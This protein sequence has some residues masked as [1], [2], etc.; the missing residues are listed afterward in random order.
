MDSYWILDLF[1]VNEGKNITLYDYNSTYLPDYNDEEGGDDSIVSV[2][3]SGLRAY[4]KKELRATYGANVSSDEK[5]DT[6]SRP[7][8]RS[9]LQAKYTLNAYKTKGKES[10]IISGFKRIIERV[11]SASSTK[12]AEIPAKAE[13]FLFEDKS[14]PSLNT[15]FQDPGGGHRVIYKLKKGPDPQPQ[16]ATQ[17][18]GP[19]GSTPPS[20]LP[21]PTQS[22]GPSQS[23]G[24]INTP[25]EPTQEQSREE[26]TGQ[27]PNN[28]EN[29]E[30]TKPSIINVFEPTIKPKTI[31]YDLPPQKDQQ[32]EIAQS[33]GNIPLVWYNSYQ[34]EAQNI[35]YFQLNTTNNLPTIKLSF[36]DPLNLMKDK[37]FPLDDTKISIFINSRSEQLKPI[38]MDF[39]IVKFNLDGASFNLTGVVDVNGLYVKKFKSMSQMS[40]FKA[41]KTIAQETGLGFNTNIDDTNDK[42]T[43]ICTGKR[44]LEFIDD[45]V[46]TSYK[47]DETYLLSYID[48]YYN[49]TYVDIEKELSRNIKEELGVSNIGL[50][51]VSKIKDKERVS[52][53]FLSNDQSMAETN[54]FFTEYKIV[55]NSTSVSLSDGYLTKVKFYDELQKDFLVFDVDSITSQGDKTII[56]KGQPQDETFYKENVNLIYNGKLDVDNMHKNFHY[57]YVQNRRNIVDLQKIGLEVKMKTPNYNLYRYQKI[58]VIVSNQ[59]S[60]PSASHLNNRLSGEWFIIDIIYRFDG[61]KYQQSIKLIK[62]E[63]NLSEQELDKE[64][65]QNQK[66]ETGQNTSNDNTQT[67]TDNTSASEPTGD[68]LMGATSSTPPP[69]DTG[70]PLTKEIFRKI[71]QGKINQKVVEQFYEPMKRSLIQYKIDSKERIA[72]F[73]S[74][75]NTETGYLLAVTEYASG[76]EYEGRTDLGNTQPGDGRKFKGRG[77][78]QLTGRSNYKKAGQFFQKDFLTDPSVVSAENNAHRKGAATEE[79]IENAILTSVRFWLKGSARGNLNDYADKMDI[80][81]PMPSSVN[82]S[83]L[84]NTHA[85]G[86]VYGSKN[87][88]NIATELAPGDANFLNI[89][90][91]SLGV[92]GGY[93]GFRERVE[94][95]I[96][97][98]SYFN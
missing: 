56:L 8:G 67:S 47:S 11:F 18:D 40:S 70:F 24:P 87:K 95:W 74:Q 62:R 3:E 27:D 73:L 53:L 33:L 85:Q 69:D 66:K 22:I 17:S 49:L 16:S 34:I 80:R 19:T 21:S 20:T 45:I 36:T 1:V 41:L 92:N 10:E 32:Q 51:E 75:V 76:N 94:A 12:K 38:H 64:P 77:L 5:Y 48:F 9:Y 50:E 89:T 13:Y 78:V 71:Y 97:I 65:E 61:G 37:G 68:Q 6:E 15:F 14:D 84:P 26:R 28:T 88:H 30:P 31:K 46:D 79:Q 81:K 59:Q 29:K 7:N 86:K 25:T 90:L 58:N 57:S 91:I 55:N 98:R 54:S 2:L 96:K 72:A 43:W 39:K 82:I 44:I 60:T 42:M 93:N 4:Y 63:L 35:S 83:D 23:N 52:K